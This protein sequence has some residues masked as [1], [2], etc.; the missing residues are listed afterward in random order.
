METSTEE[1]EDLSVLILRSNNIA[2]N[3]LASENLFA[4]VT[5]GLLVVEPESMQLKHIDQ[6]IMAG[7]KVLSLVGAVA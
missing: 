1:L 5:R 3:Q 6:S 7:R 4:A 2:V